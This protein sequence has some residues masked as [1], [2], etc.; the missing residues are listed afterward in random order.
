MV[1]LQQN[2]FVFL[3]LRFFNIVPH[4]WHRIILLSFAGRPNLVKPKL[5]EPPFLL[6]DCLTLITSLLISLYLHHLSY[7]SPRA[8]LLCVPSHQPPA[9]PTSVWLPPVNRTI[10]L[11]MPPTRHPG[12]A[13][14]YVSHQPP[15]T[16]T[17]VCLPPVTRAFLLCMAPIRHPSNPVL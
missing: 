3:I 17:S 2:I 6:D 7:P 12:L 5:S 15:A 10:P 14:L 4:W 11:C 9:P 1:L 16:P 8:S 13:T